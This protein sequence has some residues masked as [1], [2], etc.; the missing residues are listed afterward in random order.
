LPTPNG[1]SFAFL[2]LVVKDLKKAQAFY[3]AVCGYANGHVVKSAIAG[4]EMEEIIYS[5]PNGSELILLAYDSGPAPS[6]TGVISGF[7]TTD[8]AAFEKRVLAAGGAVVQPV[9]PLTFGAATMQF[10]FFSD[11]EGYVME[12]IQR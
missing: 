2:K 1:T 10:G 12:V 3:E 6:T 4:R 9:R 5:G 7:N 8:I 11:T